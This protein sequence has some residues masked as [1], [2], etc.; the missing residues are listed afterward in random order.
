MSEILDIGV[1][2]KLIP[3]K[4]QGLGIHIKVLKLAKVATTLKS[5]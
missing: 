2:Q 1:E 3:K 4:G 5:I